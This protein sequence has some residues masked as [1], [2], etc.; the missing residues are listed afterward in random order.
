MLHLLR[1]ESIDKA[2]EHYKNPEAI[3]ERNINFA[4]EKGEVYM[5]MLR[6]GCMQ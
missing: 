4:R 3:P 6:D 2:L 5:K 1:E